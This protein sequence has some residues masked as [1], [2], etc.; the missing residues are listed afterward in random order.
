V[1]QT[2]RDPNC[3]D[4]DLIDIWRVR[5][6]KERLFTWK[7]TKPL[8]QRRLD[9]WLISDTCQ[10]E[11]EEVKIILS[12]KSDHLAITLIFNGIEEQKHGPSHWKFNSSL[13]KDDEYVKQ[14]SKA[15]ARRLQVVLPDIIHHNQNAY[16]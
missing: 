10:D 13:T 4:L 12:I 5:N 8:I 16:V 6:P 3:L 11:V 1:I 2:V 7:Q 9:F 14:G 15:I